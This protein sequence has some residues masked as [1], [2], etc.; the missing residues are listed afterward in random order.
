MQR[1][2]AIVARVFDKIFSLDQLGSGQAMGEPMYGVLSANIQYCINNI[3]PCYVT[4]APMWPKSYHITGPKSTFLHHRT[5][6][7]NTDCSKFMAQ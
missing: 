3:G 1:T 6:I 2:P 5:F 4:A 7:K